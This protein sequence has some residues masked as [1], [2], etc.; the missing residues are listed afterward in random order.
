METCSFS[1]K[2]DIDSETSQKEMKSILKKIPSDLITFE[3]IIN[4]R[5]RVMQNSAKEYDKFLKLLDD[6][7]TKN[8]LD[9]GFNEA[10]CY[11]ENSL[12][13]RTQRS[14]LDSPERILSSKPLDQS[15]P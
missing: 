10:Y 1:T 3:D 2:T 8:R 9:H 4:E 14:L 7:I 12:F 6:L 5:I 11:K 13:R 15:F